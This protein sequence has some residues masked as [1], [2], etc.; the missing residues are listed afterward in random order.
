MSF[1]IATA[2]A[3]IGA[4]GGGIQMIQGNKQAKDAARK[5]ELAQAKLEEQKARWAQL[6]T[7]NPY[8]NLENVYEDLTVN[9]QQ[10]EFAR[11][12]R[13]QSQANILQSMRGAAGS[14]GIAS[15]A[16]TLANQG[17]IDA[18][19]ASALIGEQ[20][21]DIMTQRADEAS[22]LQGLEREGDLISRQAEASK[23]EALMGMTADELYNQRQQERQGQQNMMAGLGT[24]AGGMMN[25]GQL[26][27]MA[28]KFA[29]SNELGQTNT[30]M[31]KDYAATFGEFTGSMDL[32]GNMQN[33]GQT[34]DVGGIT[35]RYQLDGTLKPI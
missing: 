15:L 18:Q 16:Q 26:S 31:G 34:V 29:T 19:K 22:R 14:S 8:M 24:M 3:V 28:D 25:A 20:E 33:A 5:A 7:S 6:D 30:L 32:M 35:Y 12:E 21:Q 4:I 2:G 17:A 27:G 23:Q 11:Q 1:T 10:F 13:M 9:Q